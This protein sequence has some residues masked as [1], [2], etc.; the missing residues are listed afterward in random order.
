MQGPPSYDSAPKYKQE[1]L[2]LTVRDMTYE[3]RRYLQKK[4]DDPGVVISKIELGSK[5]S[6]PRDLS[7]MRSLRMSMTSR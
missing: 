5:A 7:P 2:G 3:V 4:D 6:E 1:A